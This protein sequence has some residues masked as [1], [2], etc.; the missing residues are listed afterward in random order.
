MH[1][2]CGAHV[3]AEKFAAPAGGTHGASLL[4]RAIG[5]PAH[6][7][8]TW[9]PGRPGGWTLL[10]TCHTAPRGPLFTLCCKVL[11]HTLGEVAGEEQVNGTGGGDSGGN[12]TP[13]AA[14]SRERP[15]A[16]ARARADVR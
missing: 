13:Q 5:D 8:S 12:A 6:E 15:P 10:V 7:L 11:L 2:G 16:A 14:D 9:P 4:P 1:A 3:K